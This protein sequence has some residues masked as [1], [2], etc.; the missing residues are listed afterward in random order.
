MC[1]QFRI[2]DWDD[3]AKLVVIDDIS[4]ERFPWKPIL[5]C[6]SEFNAS[7]KYRGVRKCR[8]GKP[9]ILCVNDEMDPRRT[10]G[11]DEYRWLIANIVFIE[12]KENLY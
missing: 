3:D 1:N 10:L 2:D 9:A 8:G 7:G 6:Q 5:G 11:R 4:T 12:V